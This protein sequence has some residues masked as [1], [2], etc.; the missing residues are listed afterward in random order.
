[1]SVLTLLSSFQRPGKPTTL[2]LTILNASSDLIANL[3]V[4]FRW[5][6]ER[7]QRSNDGSYINDGAIAFN[8]VRP[9]KTPLKPLE[10]R[11]FY[12]NE[13]YLAKEVL[14]RVAALSPERY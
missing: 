14:G 4:T 1:M 11:M 9:A 6:N 7:P 3:V 8:C 13:E 12:L 5:Q 2:G 10:E